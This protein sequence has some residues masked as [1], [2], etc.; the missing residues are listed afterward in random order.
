MKNKT[1][2]AADRAFIKKI[3]SLQISVPKSGGAAKPV[4]TFS[5]DECGAEQSFEVEAEH[6]IQSGPLKG[7]LQKLRPVSSKPPWHKN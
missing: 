6:T 7:T 3:Q 1:Q 2:R 4:E 5:C